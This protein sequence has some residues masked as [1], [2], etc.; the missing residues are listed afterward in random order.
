MIA[1]AKE[2]QESTDFG[3]TTPIMKQI[4]EEWKTIG[5]VPRKFSDQLWTE[6]RAACNIYFENLKAQKNQ[7]DPEEA[8][9]YEKKKAYL[10]TIRAFE[11][12][13]NH[14]TDLDA[15]KLHIE[16]WKSCGKVPESKRHI[17]GKF[18]KTISKNGE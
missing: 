8:E 13:G 10:D 15:I 7:V 14:K 12:T 11:M 3:A 17:E 16:N 2:L 9:A 6:F 4:Q 1:K 18:N 5:H